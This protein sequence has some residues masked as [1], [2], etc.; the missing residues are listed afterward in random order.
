ML[1]AW[2]EAPQAVLLASRFRHICQA[3]AGQGHPNQASA[4]FLE[5]LP[6][7]CGLGQTFGQFI[8]F[9][10]ILFPFVLFVCCCSRS[11]ETAEAVPLFKSVHGHRAEAGC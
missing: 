8:E 10:F 9:V 1:R 2:A 7:C 6:A 5:R 11:K 4:E 3:E